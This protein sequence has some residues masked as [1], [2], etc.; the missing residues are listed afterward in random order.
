RLVARRNERVASPRVPGIVTDALTG[1]RGGN[2]RIHRKCTGNLSAPARFRLSAFRC[3][4]SA[5]GVSTF[6]FPPLYLPHFSSI[7]MHTCEE[8][9]RGG[10]SIPGR[11]LS[12]CRRPGFRKLLS[13]LQEG[14]EL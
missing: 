6:D 7:L 13:P 8:V 9:L 5:L 4:I 12:Q 2:E 3:Q 11:I 1:T 14:E 10:Q